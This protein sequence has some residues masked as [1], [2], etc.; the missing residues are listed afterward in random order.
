MSRAFVR[1]PDGDQVIDDLPELPQVPVPNYV[2]PAGFTALESWR[3]RLKYERDSLTGDADSIV[4][5]SKLAHVNR[6]LRYIEGRIGHAVVVDPQ[7]QPADE[8][9]FGATVDANDT[10]GT[11]HTWRIVGENEADIDKGMVSW[12]SPLARALTGAGVGDVVTWKRPAG[13]L[14]LEITAIRYR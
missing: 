9:A 13:D 12:V 8:V 11:A 3:D 7:D 2:T 5:K 1:E 6:D 14:E 4:D 10:D